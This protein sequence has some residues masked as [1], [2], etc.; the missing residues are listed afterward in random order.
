M[1]FF[2]AFASAMQDSSQALQPTWLWFS[3]FEMVASLLVPHFS[4]LFFI[5][6][7]K[8]YYHT[9]LSWHCSRR[10][11]DSIGC[12]PLLSFLYVSLDLNRRQNFES[13]AVVLPPMPI[14][15]MDLWCL[16]NSQIRTAVIHMFSVIQCCREYHAKVLQLRFMISSSNCPSHPFFQYT[17]LMALPT[18]AQSWWQIH[19]CHNSCLRPCIWNL[20]LKSTVDP[21]EMEVL[22]GW[23]S[24]AMSF[25]INE[26]GKNKISW[27]L[28]VYL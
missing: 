22:W 8:H 23:K 28:G 6:F 3:A 20:I 5:I 27:R 19:G 13:R 12:G 14:N 26:R 18:H 15:P 7:S 17:C 16:L 25:S 11:I 1:V 2:L 10:S 24:H 9:T 21:R 4:T